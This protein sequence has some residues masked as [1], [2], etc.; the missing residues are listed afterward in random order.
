M[1]HYCR[2]SAD[3]CSAAGMLWSISI[4]FETPP[5]RRGGGGARVVWL[6]DGPFNSC[7]DLLVF[8]MLAEW[9]L[10]R[11]YAGTVMKVKYVIRPLY[12]NVFLK[13][14]HMAPND[15]E[16]GGCIC[17]CARCSSRT[18]WRLPLII[19]AAF[20]GAICWLW[21]S[22]RGGGAQ[23]SVSFR[24]T[25]NWFVGRSVLPV[26]SLPENRPSRASNHPHS[27]E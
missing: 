15:G 2:S 7:L 20:P 23:N 26:R 5:M 1:P 24:R 25:S 6:S 13:I 14:F 17:S 8:T 12:P 10:S 22:N 27:E 3:C 18:C 4:N 19:T 21:T 11:S 9:C 16:Q